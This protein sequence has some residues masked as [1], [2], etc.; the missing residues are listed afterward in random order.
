MQK[1]ALAYVAAQL[2]ACEKVPA[3]RPFRSRMKHIERVCLWLDRLLTQGGVE[4]TAA[5]RLAAAFHDVGY[6]DPTQAHASASA[7]ML[8]AYAL[9]KRIPR[10]TAARAVFLVAEHSDKR[11]WLPDPQAPRDLVLLMEADLLDEE[12]ALGLVFD[13][14]S[15][16]T[17]GAK[18]FE[19][20]YAR[21]LQYEPE[22]L[23]HNPMVTP[24]ARAFWT[25][26]QRIIRSFMAALAFDLGME[27]ES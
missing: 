14:M 27:E 13:C 4:D 12:G 19:D 25:D 21:M 7:Q 24:L 16:V 15:A 17:L 9:A 5:V 23:R 6:T 11:R 3:E 2:E 20:A 18:G 10:E 8:E 22:R 1:E 26:K